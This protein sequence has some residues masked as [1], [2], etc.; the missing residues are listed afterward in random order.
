[1]WTIE[2]TARINLCRSLL[3]QI[4]SDTELDPYD[5]SVV[6]LRHMIQRRLTDLEL[7]NAEI[8]LT[9]EKM[10]SGNAGSIS[11]LGEYLLSFRPKS[12][13]KAA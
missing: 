2:L 7:I 8:R 13:N 9:E 5:P 3:K 6:K 4:Q 12:T 1:M 10:L 11:G